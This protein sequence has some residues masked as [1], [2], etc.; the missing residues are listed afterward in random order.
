MTESTNNFTISDDKSTLKEDENKVVLE[1]NTG[2]VRHHTLVPW[3][4]YCSCGRWQEYRFPCRHAM[5]FYRHLEEKS[6]EEIV[7]T[8]THYYY[9]YGSLQKVYAHS[10]CPVVTEMLI[11]DNETRP[12]LCEKRKSGRPQKKRL[13]SRSQYEDPARDS[14]IRCSSC[15]ERGHNKRTCRRRA[16]LKEEAKEDLEGVKDAR[17]KSPVEK[18]QRIKKEETKRSERNRSVSL[19]K[20]KKIRSLYHSLLGLPVENT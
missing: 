17:K 20:S 10:V 16:E 14:V 8:K 3:K 6:F 11:S 13:R 9:T 5:A 18:K 12:P 1:V 7:S 19:K 15:G 4:E 2:N